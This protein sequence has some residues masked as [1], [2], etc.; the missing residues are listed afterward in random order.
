MI[1]TK[2]KHTLQSQQIVIK[3]DKGSDDK[4]YVPKVAGSA[5]PLIRFYDETIEFDSIE[6]LN[7]SF[8]G[9]ILPTVN[10][11]LN[12]ADEKY[13]HEYPIKVGSIFTVFLGLANDK[14][15]QPIK[16]DFYL[17]GAT[18]GSFSYNLTGILHI[19][20]MYIPTQR[21]FQNKTSLEIF[22]QIARE[23]HLGFSTNIDNTNDRMNWL[24]YQGN[25]DFLNYLANRSYVSDN[26]L[27]KVFVDQFWNLNVIDVRKAMETKPFDTFITE[28]VTGNPM[29]Q[30]D[31]VIAATN[32]TQATETFKRFIY[33]E[34]TMY[35]DYSTIALTQPKTFNFVD[36]NVSTF[37]KTE[38]LL[39]SP[40]AE[41]IQEKS[42]YTSFSNDNA[43]A[44][45]FQT[46]IKNSY[47]EL[48]LKGQRFSAVVP[49]YIPGMY[50]FMSYNQEIYNPPLHRAGNTSDPNTTLDQDAE[51]KPAE[52]SMK[53]SKN[54]VMS[55]DVLVTGISISYSSTMKANTSY[56]SMNLSLLLKPNLGTIDQPEKKL[57]NYE[58]PK[59]QEPAIPKTQPAQPPIKKP[60]M[61]PNSKY[62]IEKAVNY[63]NANVEPTSIS[64][65]A[66]YV[67]RAIVAGGL[68]TAGNPT[69][70]K[71]YDWFLPKLGFTEVIGDVPMYG[72]IVVIQSIPGHKHGHIC[73]WNGSQWVSDFKQNFMLPSQAY[74]NNPPRVNYYRWT[75]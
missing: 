28:P 7:F 55:G 27:I 24:Q 56:M 10:I 67:R 57:M 41:H 69:S 26:T 22:E 50:M 70:A 45:Y 37:D 23:C 5:V 11:T 30:N 74:R 36:F 48:M 31:T 20:E 16:G 61:N 62:N 8:G 52:A 75:K 64:Q 47:N 42:T 43:Y 4:G 49:Y 40:H 54:T 13:K 3:V 39:T 14:A 68:S 17:S 29:G 71:D 51:L 53:A 2:F 6:S 58:K 35:D 59:Y 34:F 44:G 12:D 32:I 38:L 9:S 21:V 18:S 19:P 33:D 25:L 15:H 63:I 66:K 1:K 65:C 73:M 46:K 60:T 72:D